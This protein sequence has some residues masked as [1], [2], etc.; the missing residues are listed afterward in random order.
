VIWISVILTVVAFP[1]PRAEILV[2]L[3]TV[4]AVIAIPVTEVLLKLIVIVGTVV[5]LQYELLSVVAVTK[6]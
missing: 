6:L 3:A 1:A 2:L 4:A 5:P